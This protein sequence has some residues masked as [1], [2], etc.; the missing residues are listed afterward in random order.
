MHIPMQSGRVSFAGH[1]YEQ[2]VG[3]FYDITGLAQWW[4]VSRQA[5]AAGV[6][7]GTVIACQLVGGQWV[8]PT[9]QC[10]GSGEV[11]PHLIALWTIL[12]AAVDP[13]SCAV[14]LRSPQPELDGLGAADW[15][16]GGH[17]HEAALKLARS[18]AR[19]WAA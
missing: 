2:L 16:T 12:R 5:I 10:T 13:W 3:P 18:D 11:H 9:W 6:A 1:S 7:D 14:W 4:G 15:I 17:S 8:Y 19:R